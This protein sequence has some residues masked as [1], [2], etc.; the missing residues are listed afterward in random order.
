MRIPVA[1][2]TLALTLIVSLVGCGDGRPKVV[3]VSG[4]VLMNGKPVTG[5]TGFVRVEP[6]GGRPAIG[7]INT[8]DGTFTLTTFE[9]GDG[10]MPGTHPAA[11][12]VNTT[13]GGKLISLIP[14]K[15][16]DAK[17]SGLQVTVD[18]PT[19]S[20]KIE[21]TGELKQA[22]TP[23]AAELQGDDPGY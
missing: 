9:Q 11:V 8:A 16:G 17:T 12:I 23:S 13:V 20:L 4:Q 10:C 1:N 3:P 6:A 21:L 7:E 22:P 18:E 5:R 19:D 15:Y 14:E 2:V